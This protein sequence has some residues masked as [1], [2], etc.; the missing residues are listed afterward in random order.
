[1]ETRTTLALMPA[2]ISGLGAIVL[3]LLILPL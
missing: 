3:V 1:M 2:R